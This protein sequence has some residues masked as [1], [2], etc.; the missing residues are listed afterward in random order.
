MVVGYI[1]LDM[2]SLPE[3]L[4]EKTTGLGKLIQVVLIVFYLFELGIFL[5]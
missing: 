4:N 5:A 3:M 2:T 1:T